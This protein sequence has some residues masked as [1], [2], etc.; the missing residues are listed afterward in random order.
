MSGPAAALKA[1]VDR[2]T[3]NNWINQ[4]YD[5]QLTEVEAVANVFG[6]TAWQMGQLEPI[7]FGEVAQ[8]R[9]NTFTNV[10][11]VILAALCL[12]LLV[13]AC[14]LAIN[15]GASL[16]ERKRPFTLPG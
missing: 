2:K 6:L 10:E 13:A 7:T 1:G 5:P 3:V 8:L 4:R 16:V 9:K 12:T 14:S 11:R 15:V